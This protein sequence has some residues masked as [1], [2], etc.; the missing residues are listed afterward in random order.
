[1][2]R[3]RLARTV[4]RLMRYRMVGDVPPS[5][6][7]VG[8][9][10]TSNWDFITMLLVMWHGGA[11]PRVLVKKQLFKGPLGWVLKALG[12]IPLDRD[13]AAGVVRDL[14]DEAKRGDGEPFRLIL[15]AEGTRSRGEYWKSGFL[16]LSRET[17]LPITLAFFE[18]P[19]RTMGFGPTFHATDDVTADMDVVRAFYAD[20]HGIK[21]KNATPPRLREEA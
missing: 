11:H 14:A 16:R 2:I 5:G 7:L 13:N 8:A 3:Q 4:V 20:K 1:M 15:A 21:P 19:T 10:H 12:G 17:G 9:P 18:P 6:I